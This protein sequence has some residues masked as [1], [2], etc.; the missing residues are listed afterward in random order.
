MK[1]LYAYFYPE[2]ESCSSPL[3]EILGEILARPGKGVRSRLL[4]LA[5]KTGRPDEKR[6]Q[7]LAAGIEILHLA[8]LVHDDLLDRGEVR[9]G[10]P[11]LWKKYGDE[12]AVLVGD[13]LLAAAYKTLACSAGVS[14]LERINRLLKEMVEAE[15]EQETNSFK[16]IS[17]PLYL[18]RVE[19]KTARFFQTICELGAEAGGLSREKQDALGKFGQNAGMVYQLLDDLLDIVG[20]PEVTGKPVFQDLKNGVLTLPYLLLRSKSGLKKILPVIR[21]EKKVSPALQKMV[22]HLLVEQDALL[23][24]G[25]KIEQYFRQAEQSL[26]ATGG[27]ETRPLL[28]FLEGIRLK[29]AQDLSRPEKSS[30]KRVELWLNSFGR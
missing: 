13:F 10:C 28:K 9:R 6:L 24:T 26:L 21:E 12:A 22:R 5:A 3:K 2:V 15:L 20:D 23:K 11:A 8:T 25:Q 29:A 4:F 30:S 14:G 19:K 17:E 7:A 16:F 18:Q 1:N 27:L